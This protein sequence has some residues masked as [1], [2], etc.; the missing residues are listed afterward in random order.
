MLHPLFETLTESLTEE[1]FLQEFS[2]KYHYE[3]PQLPTLAA[4]AV[5][6]QKVVLNNVRDGI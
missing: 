4:V 5:S 3:E 1:L 2:K 6:M